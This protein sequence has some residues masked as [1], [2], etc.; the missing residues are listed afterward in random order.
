MPD[1]TRDPR[2]EAGTPKCAPSV[3]APS[4]GLTIAIDGPAGVGKSVIS[5]RLASALGYLFLDTGALYRAVTLAALRRNLP[6]DDGARLGDLATHL[7]LEML[8][9]TIGDGRQYTVR[10]DGEDVTWQLPTPEVDRSVSQVAAHPEVR[11]ALLN[12][13]RSL[14]RGGVVMAGRDIGT[15]VLP[16]ADVKVFLTASAAV[17]ARRR[18]NQLRSRGTAADYATVLAEIERRDEIDSNRA[19]SPLR[20][21]ADAVIIDTDVMTIAEEIAAIRAL[22]ER[23]KKR[24]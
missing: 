23:A 17:R 11:R 7:R 15:V 24:T 1:Q 5:A 10:L 14:A 20:P 16:S 6:L 4:R 9:P 3:D 19:V 18:C 13:Q 2:P 8:R 22:C 12:M 21:A